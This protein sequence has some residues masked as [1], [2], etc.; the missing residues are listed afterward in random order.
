MCSA[1]GLSPNLL[2]P[3]VHQAFCYTNL[4]LAEQPLPRYMSVVSHTMGLPQIKSDETSHIHH[5]LDVST[6]ILEQGLDLLENYLTSDEQLMVDSKFVHGSTIG[7]HLRHARDHFMLL[8][9]A[10]AA[11]SPP[12]IVDYD[13]RRRN[14]PM[15]NSIKA[16]HEALTECVERLRRE[17]PKLSVNEPLT[18]NA[19]TPYPQTFQSTF[20]RELWFAGLHAE[21]HWSMV[22][23]HAG[24]LGINLPESFGFAPSTLVHHGTE[25]PL[26]KAK[27]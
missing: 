1:N 19:I 24:E 26:G 12:Y 2:Q 3:T 23:V 5:L 25:A 7:K 18:L 22:R 10:M 20:G 8:L 4:Y 15:E 9:D 13:V 6:I 11:P 16:A 17:V 14:Q 27:I 21:H